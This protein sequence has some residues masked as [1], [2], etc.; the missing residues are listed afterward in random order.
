MCLLIILII[1]ICQL[2]FFN[3]FNYLYQLFF[4]FNQYYL[5]ITDAVFIID[6]LIFV[7]IIKNVNKFNEYKSQWG[8]FDVIDF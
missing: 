3:V 6:I 8:K 7:K 2:F 1:N 5:S 4:F